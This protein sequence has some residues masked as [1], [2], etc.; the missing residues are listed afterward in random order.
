VSEKKGAKI[1]IEVGQLAGT[2]VWIDDVEIE[3]LL[4]VVVSHVAG[5]PSNVVL[6]V[7]P[8]VIEIAGLVDEVKRFEAIGRL[9]E[10]IS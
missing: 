1:R 3:H 2:R 10:A 6:G 9:S 7:R 5:R 8:A 4:S